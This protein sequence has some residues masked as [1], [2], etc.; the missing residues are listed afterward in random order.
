MADRRSRVRPSHPPARIDLVGEA[1]LLATLNDA[2]TLEANARAHH[3]AARIGDR[4]PGVAGIEPAVAGHASVLLRFD[5]DAIDEAAVRTL[6]LDALAEADSIEPVDDPAV[7]EI[8]AAYGGADGPDLPEVATRT[9]LTEAE[10]VRRHVAVEH[11]V[12]AIGFVPGFPYL[13]TLPAELDLPRRATPRER[14][15]AGSVAIAGRQTGLY[16]FETPGGWHVIGRTDARLWDAGRDR[17]LLLAPG[18][19]VRLV[20]G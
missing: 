10:V 18:D 17:P 13:G 20:P 14:V 19:R 3:L 16:P 5:P 2:L 6:L 7:H 9:G 1:A 11:T 15:P 12:L 4:L 8:R